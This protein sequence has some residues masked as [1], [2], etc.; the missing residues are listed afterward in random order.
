LASELASGDFAL[1]LNHDDALQSR[2]FVAF[3]TMN[4]VIRTSDSIGVH[5]QTV[6]RALPGTPQMAGTA[7]R[8]QVEANAESRTKLRA[9]AIERETRF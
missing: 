6:S 9:N 8:R 5:R 2:P 7:R 3:G 1:A 4:I